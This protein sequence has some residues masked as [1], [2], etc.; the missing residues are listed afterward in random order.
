MKE[1]TLLNQNALNV[2]NNSNKDFINYEM[3]ELLFFKNDMLKDMKKLD[4][5]FTFKIAEQNS[6]NSEQF[7]KIKK[8]LNI[9]S[10]QISQTNSRISKDI[11]FSEKIKDFQ[12]FKL[13]TE[14][15]I[16]RLNSKIIITQK[17][18]RDFINKFEKIVDDNLKYPGIIGSNAKFLNF[19]NF[20]DYS[21]SYFN[22]FIKFREYIK[23]FGL[24][25]FKRKINSDIQE[26]RFAII[27]NYKN[28][29][30][31]VLNNLKEFDMKMEDI[32]N[33]NKKLMKENENK[34]EDWTKKF[35]DFLSEYQTKFANLEKETK[36]KYAEHLN[37]MENLKTMKNQFF[38]DMNNIKSNL[39]ISTKNIESKIKEI[40]L[41]KD[42]HDNQQSFNEIGK[43]K[44]SNDLI[45]KKSLFEKNKESQFLL[46]SNNNDNHE[47]EQRKKKNN[48]ILNQAFINSNFNKID[49]YNAKNSNITDKNQISEEKSITEHSSDKIIHVHEIS[50]LL[51]RTQ[52]NFR[53]RNNYFSDNLKNL[54]L[55]KNLSLTVEDTMTKKDR[56]A[57][58][59]SG[60]KRNL[61]KFDS[62][63]YSELSKNNSIRNNYS[64]SNISNMKIKKVILPFY[65]NNKNRI[66]SARNIKL[67][68]KK[69]KKI[70]NNKSFS[71]TKKSF[72]FNI[73]EV[74]KSLFGISK[75]NKNKDEKIKALPDSARSI[76]IN[77]E[78]DINENLDSLM[79]IKP[80]GKNIFSN[81]VSNSRKVKKRSS[82]FNEEKYT[83]DE[84]S[85]SR[86]KK[87]FYTKYKI[88]ELLLMNSKNIK[89][90]SKI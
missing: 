6:I 38:L 58:L 57:I 53:L 37:E 4:D 2:F 69:L 86:L 24:D 34:F 79:L 73:N 71:S 5:K 43:N 26:F 21:L 51:E 63:K 85:Q 60:M 88:G 83:K 66:Q 78:N 46:I 36:D 41:T 59:K 40:S 77:R 67:D 72:L 70:P 64:V 74:E 55:K 13:K 56:L 49:A 10:Q 8:Q 39:E 54:D 31:L 75:K 23:N 80:K 68:N 32:I 7:D 9:L 76:K 17:E 90:S 20:I 87:N 84:Q 62:T 12:R 25:D 15:D 3:Q 19:R 18:Q 29:T 42:N 30:R 89:K 45:I 28:S 50:K 81:S 14:D 11:D 82:S 48:F 27:D 16:N 33:S 44:D 61:G 1:K 22:E 52:N 65:I 47:I 35:N